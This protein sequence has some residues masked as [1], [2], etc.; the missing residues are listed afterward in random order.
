MSGGFRTSDRVRVASAKPIPG[1]E[2]GDKGTVLSGPH[3]APSGT[4]YY[5]L[6]M[7]R[8]ATEESS[9]FTANEIE[10]DD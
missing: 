5:L 8:D 10:R 9:L 6:R 2:T 1:Y 3:T 4:L 7:D